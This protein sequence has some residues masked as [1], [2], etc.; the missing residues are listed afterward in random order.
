MNDVRLALRTLRT[1][2]IVTL[3]VILSLALGIGA[4]SAMFS[5][6]NS[7]LLRALPVDRPERLVLLLSNPLVT[8]SSPW[9]NP[10]W[11][12]IRDYHADLFQGVFAS[13]AEPPGSTSRKVDR[14]ISSM[15]STPVANT[16]PRWA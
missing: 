6:V 7:L 10:V 14:P 1:T 13:H 12:Q 5:I 2:P 16:S 4:N 3:V 11:E 8:P 15:A 9:S